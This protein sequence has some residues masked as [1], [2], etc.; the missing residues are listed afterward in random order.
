[1]LM[2]RILTLPI[3]MLTFSTLYSAAIK[4]PG[5]VE[6]VSLSMWPL[7]AIALLVK[8]FLCIFRFAT[9]KKIQ[10]LA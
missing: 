1:M 2:L 9:G 5:T 6:F 8:A 4:V 10:E 7:L 3:A